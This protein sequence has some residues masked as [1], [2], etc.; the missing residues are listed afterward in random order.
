VS[1]KSQFPTFNLEDKVVI[2]R[3]SIVRN[4]D[5]NG[6]V[7]ENVNLGG[8]ADSLIDHGTVRLRVWKVYSR[9]GRKVTTV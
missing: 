9:R 5:A 8:P 6:P 1:L 4:A 7:P 2:S 3:G